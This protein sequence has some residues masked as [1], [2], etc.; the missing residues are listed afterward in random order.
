[1]PDKIKIPL[2]LF[3]THERLPDGGYVFTTHQFVPGQEP[4]AVKLP[5]AFN[6]KKLSIQQAEDGSL[7][8]ELES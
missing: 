7:Y 1:M 5:D 2:T 3:G 4:A 8:L 6:F